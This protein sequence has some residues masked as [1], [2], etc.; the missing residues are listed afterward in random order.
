M[1]GQQVAGTAREFRVQ[2]ECEIGGSKHF[3]DQKHQ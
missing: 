2:L 3:I 1:A